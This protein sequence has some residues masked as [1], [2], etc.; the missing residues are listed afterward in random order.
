ML[1]VYIGK[2]F[3]SAEIHATTTRLSSAQCTVHSAQ[4]NDHPQ[5]C[6]SQVHSVTRT[7]H[8]S[9]A[10]LASAILVLLTPPPQPRSAC[11]HSSQ[12]PPVCRSTQLDGRHALPTS[13]CSGSSGEAEQCIRSKC[14]P[15]SRPLI[16]RDNT[17]LLRSENAI[18]PVT[19][20]P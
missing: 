20:S 9:L 5:H 13:G 8:W 11:P 2:L 12:R 4:C 16:G 15:V 14:G 19:H 6:C 3:I 7:V 1:H 18:M 17:W 10:D